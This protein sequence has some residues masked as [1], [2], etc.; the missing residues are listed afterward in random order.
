MAKK[1]P[2]GWNPKPI[3]LL[4]G[5]KASGKVNLQPKKF[6]DLVQQ[7][8]VRVNVYRS[9]LCSNVKSIDGAEHE[10]DCELCHGVGYIDRYPIETLAF[11]QTQVL[12][13]TPFAE[14]LYDGNTVAMTFLQGIELQYFTLIEMCDFTDI[15][16]QRVKRQPGAVD[17]LKYK[18]SRVNMLV[19]KNGLEYHEGIHFNIDINGNIKWCSGKGPARS[20]IY[21]IHYE[22]AIRFRATKAIHVNRF[23]QVATKE[24]IQMHKMPEM[25]MA[26]KEFLVVRRDVNG[27]VLEPNN[28]TD[29]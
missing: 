17:V 11:I 23:A 28:I 14:G 10:I 15:Y 2:H 12:E 20:L 5:S 18:A 21:S 29:D 22:A 9:A 8:G 6:D 16:Y 24:G 26:S 4:P 13:N 19:D 3:P 7:Q 1:P 27:N 25:W